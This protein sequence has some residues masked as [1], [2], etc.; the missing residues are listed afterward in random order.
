LKL[1]HENQLNHLKNNPITL[2]DVQALNQPKKR[3]Y[4]ILEA[5]IKDGLCNYVYEMTEGKGPY[6]KHKV[7]GKGFIMDD[8][9][10]IFDKFRVHMAAIDGVFKLRAMELDDIDR[11]HNDDVVLGY[12]VDG[13]KMKGSDEME[14]IILVGSKPIQ[15]CGARQ[16]IE[17]PKID[18]TSSSGY[19]WYNE[20]KELADA[21]R[22]EV[23]LYKEGK[24]TV[25]DTDED[26]V[27]DPNQLSIDWES[28][29]ETE[30]QDDNE[31]EGAKV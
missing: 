1:K 29:D 18:I 12:H 16:R 25:P 10:E 23:A 15:E 27:D 28:G 22:E 24:Y 17:T 2:E 30:L 31:F 19:Q 11:Y 13:F 5:E 7:S 20:L 6:D 9:R 26:D 14:F 3:P 8:M 4:K 21:A